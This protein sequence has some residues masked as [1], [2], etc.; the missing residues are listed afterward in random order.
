MPSLSASDSTG[1]QSLI[2][3]NTRGPSGRSTYAWKY[4]ALN[5]IEAARAMV[6]LKSLPVRP[7]SAGRIVSGGRHVGHT[8]MAGNTTVPQS[9]QRVPIKAD[10]CSWN[11]TQPG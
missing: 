11:D 1:T 7:T 6:K 4:G 10:V 5:P 9:L 8:A 2:R 3:E